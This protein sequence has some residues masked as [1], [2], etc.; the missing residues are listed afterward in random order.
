MS[1]TLLK[2]GLIVSLT[3]AAITI[4]AGCGEETV[5]PPVGPTVD[6]S[7][8]EVQPQINTFL[9]SAFVAFSAGFSSYN[10][11]PITDNDITVFYGPGLPGDVPQSTYE[12]TASGWHLITYKSNGTV[13][14]VTVNDSLQFSLAFTV[15]QDPAGADMLDY[16]HHWSVTAVDQ[17]G[18]FS[19][20]NGDALVVFFTLT[21]TSARLVGDYDFTSIENTVVSGVT[22]NNTFVF[23]AEFTDI[24]VSKPAI[25]DWGSGCPASGT[26]SFTIN[27][28]KVVTSSAGVTT[29]PTIWTG[30]AVFVNGTATIT[31]SN[32]VDNFSYTRVVCAPTT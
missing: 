14:V 21:G 30:T 26:I 22:T 27:Q 6:P 20:S 10:E 7:F 28:S 16:R 4:A 3:L 9:D 23:A 15:Q 5:D 11:V 1:A 13:T 17:T 31:L 18:N 8:A 2:R 19:D 32:T 29:T 24:N 25:G 12:Y